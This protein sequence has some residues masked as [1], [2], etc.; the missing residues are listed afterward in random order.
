METKMNKNTLLSA[1]FLASMAAPAAANCYEVIGCTDSQ[2]F[3]REQLEQLSCQALWEVRNQIFHENGYCFQTE[4]GTATFSND[5][6][7]TDD[8][9]DVSLNDHER[10]N[11][12]IIKSVERSNGC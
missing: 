6:C 2:S 4:R 3:E 1:L 12:T 9:A 7:T 5:Q 8:A 10:S 11:I